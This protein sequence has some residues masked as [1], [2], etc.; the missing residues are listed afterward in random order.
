MATYS[1]PHQESQ[2]E[3]RTTTW[4]VLGLFGLLG[5][6]MLQDYLHA[7][8]HHYGFYWSESLLFKSFW[9]LFLPIAWAQRCVLHRTA[10]LTL[11]R[12]RRRAMLLAVA[13]AGMH[14]CAFA[15]TVCGLSALLFDHTYSIDRL[16]HYT[17]AEDL[18]KYALIYTALGLVAIRPA[19]QPAP[20]AP[21]TPQ[22]FPT[23]LLLGTG[24]Q[25]IALDVDAI[26]FI[27]AAT[28]YSLIHTQAKKQLHTASLK[29]LQATLN[30]AQFVRIHKST[31]V[32]LHQ[33]RAYTSR[34][35]GDYDVHLTSGHNLRLSRR[36]APAFK[37]YF[38]LR[39]S[40]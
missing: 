12:R 31:I 18:Y 40:S 37:Q 17:L 33:V 21:S 5:L 38:L 32:N 10:A 20:A 11:T 27:E 23:K 24:R 2:P 22:S 3:S 1:L 6:T 13:A 7:T 36:Y 29:A 8:Q 16:L 28:P 34:L 25:T 4:L 9:V 30:P 35:N 26:L 19:D 39:S 14:L 15:L